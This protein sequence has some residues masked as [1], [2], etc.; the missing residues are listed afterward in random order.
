L[1]GRQRVPDP[2]D[3]LQPGTVWVGERTYRAGAYAGK[4]V[5]YELHVQQRDGRN[6]TGHKYDNGPRR[7]RVE[8]EGTLDGSDI[9]WSEND[10]NA[11]L[12][13]RG[14]I[15]GNRIDLTFDAVFSN[16]ATTQ[17]DGKLHC[18]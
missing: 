2:A 15:A 1:A 16:R 12:T 11:M 17:G 18:Q 14:S 3:R 10:G 4:T 9:T 6:F 8:V 5:T 13:V 7:N